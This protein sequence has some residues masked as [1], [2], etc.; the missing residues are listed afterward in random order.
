MKR[1]LLR[2]ATVQGTGFTLNLH[3]T[4]TFRSCGNQG[5]NGGI[6]RYV[7]KV[8][9]D[10]VQSICV[11]VRRVGVGHHEDAVPDSQTV[12]D[13]AAMRRVVCVVERVIGGGAADRGKIPASR[14]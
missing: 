3:L 2:I 1:S 10:V 14:R 13:D 11:H 5:G 4:S 6:E 7:A 12:Q 8:E 9:I